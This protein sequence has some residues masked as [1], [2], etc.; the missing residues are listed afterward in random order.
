MLGYLLTGSQLNANNLSGPSFPTSIESLCTYNRDECIR[1][2]QSFGTYLE[3]N[4][5]GIAYP[6]LSNPKPGSNKF[7]SGGYIT[8]N[9]IS[10]INAI[11]T[12]LPYSVRV[13]V[14]RL[15]Y[16]K[17]YAQ[18]LVEYMQANNLLHSSSK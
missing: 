11:Q 18:A 9:Y 13:G 12:E 8:S 7:Y 5:L 16:A 4:G 10:Q 6:S 1:G 14:D 3:S 2:S 17:N 15:T